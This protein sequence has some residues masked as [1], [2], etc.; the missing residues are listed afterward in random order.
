MLFWRTLTC[1][2]RITKYHVFKFLFK[3]SSTSGRVFVGGDPETKISVRHLQCIPIHVKQASTSRQRQS[4]CTTHAT[5][6]LSASSS[7]VSLLAELINS[8]QAH[9]AHC[10]GN[11]T[12]CWKYFMINSSLRPAFHY[13]LAASD[14]I[15]TTPQTIKHGQFWYR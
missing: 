15:H 11:I 5:C 1:I 2:C 4:H 10:D 14:Y 6:V 3:Y 9:C 7:L 12:V 13:A 8:C